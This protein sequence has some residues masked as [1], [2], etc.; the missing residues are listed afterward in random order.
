M[1]R[2][3]QLYKARDDLMREFTLCVIIG[4]NERFAAKAWLLKSLEDPEEIIFTIF[5]TQI[6]SLEEEKYDSSRIN[7]IM[8]V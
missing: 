8:K 7:W 2:T 4:R 6:Q 1:N 5:E 3:G